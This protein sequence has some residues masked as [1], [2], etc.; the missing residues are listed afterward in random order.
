MRRVLSGR[1]RRAEAERP[2]SP[3]KA[4]WVREEKSASSVD[5][6]GLEE[7]SRMALDPD[8]SETDVEDK[9]GEDDVEGMSQGQSHSAGNRRT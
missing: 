3:N 7:D 2:V 6:K 1:A 4:K 8:R 5:L 9:G